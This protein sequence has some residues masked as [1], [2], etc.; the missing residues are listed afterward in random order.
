LSLTVLAAG[1]LSLPVFGETPADPAREKLIKY[2]KIQIPVDG[3]R[4]FY[5][6]DPLKARSQWPWNQEK[7]LT[8]DPSVDE[9]NHTQTLR[10]QEDQFVRGFEDITSAYGRVL[11]V[12]I[13]RKDIPGAPST[14][15]EHYLIP[16]QSGGATASYKQIHVNHEKK[17]FLDRP[18]G[19]PATLTKEPG[20]TWRDC[21]TKEKNSVGSA[22]SLD[23][24][25]DNAQDNCVGWPDSRDE[26][27]V[28]DSKIL[29]E[30]DPDTGKF[31]DKQYY[32]VHTAYKRASCNPNGGTGELDPDYHELVYPCSPKEGWIPA[33]DVI[34]FKRD[35]S[36]EVDSVEKQFY[37]RRQRKKAI[38]CKHHKTTPAAPGLE[39]Q[40][41]KII[42]AMDFQLDQVL[43]LIG[44]CFPAKGSESAMR[45]WANPFDHYVRKHWTS[46]GAPRGLS[47]LTQKQLFA[48]DAMARALYGESRSC[49]DNS[50]G[51]VKG[52]ARTLMNRSVALAMEQGQVEKFSTPEGV[53]QLEQQGD[54]S[55]IE[56]LPAVIAAKSQVS[57]FNPTDP[58]LRITMCPEK[59]A[60]LSDKDQDNWE[61]CVRVALQSV[62]DFQSLVAETPSITEMFYTA[63]VTPD[64]AIDHSFKRVT[65]FDY[66]SKETSPAGSS[67]AKIT[68]LSNPGCLILWQPTDK[69]KDPKLMEIEPLLKN[70]DYNLINPKS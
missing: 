6:D 23:N 60:K 10:F 43:P 12:P 69:K 54:L 14:A 51:Y 70:P 42:E 16:L 64:F 24:T 58:N 29:S 66:I 62:T 22:K 38:Q 26:L 50:I 61:A 30:F 56:I 17:V 35:D 21:A 28:I 18:G 63:N 47:G 52:V 40:V 31:H 19:V 46:P 57:S 48:V 44:K 53:R 37:L 34:D 15:W 11:V 4:S 27:T 41:D 65:K 3:F 39:G 2:Y 13:Q 59:E 20:L 25:V 67:S 55:A 1:L 8:V 36:H 45:Q 32:K 68:K 33:S 7:V 5:S 49:I 9:T